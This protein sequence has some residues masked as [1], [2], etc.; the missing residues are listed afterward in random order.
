MEP[1]VD[2]A[3][4]P[5][6]EF[7]NNSC[8]AEPV[9]DQAQEVLISS[10]GENLHKQRGSNTAS[11]TLAETAHTLSD[12]TLGPAAATEVH[13]QPCSD[14]MADM[15]SQEQTSFSTL[16]SKSDIVADGGHSAIKKGVK[17]SGISDSEAAQ[18]LQ[19][20]FKSDTSRNLSPKSPVP[21]LLS[22]GALSRSLGSLPLN[23]DVAIS[24]QEVILPF[25][26]TQGEDTLK[27]DAQNKQDTSEKGNKPIPP[28][29][30]ALPAKPT[31]P[32][33]PSLPSTSTVQMRP[34]PP[35]PAKPPVP[36]S[37]RLSALS[38]RSSASDNA[39]D[40][41]FSTIS[42]D[43]QDTITLSSTFTFLT[44]TVTSSITSET[45]NITSPWTS[46]SS[47]PSELGSPTELPMDITSEV[48]NLIQIPS[49]PSSIITSPDSS[50]APSPGSSA[51]PSPASSLRASP[52]A[53][54]RPKRARKFRQYN[55][56]SSCDGDR[57]DISSI[58]GELNL[59]IVIY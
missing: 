9:V 54:P 14:S 53:P 16:A 4:P 2:P 31:L 13:G 44:S 52:R 48:Q 58:T 51:V 56:L 43:S 57:S 3:P 23:P 33:K 46:T 36:K 25:Q 32:A 45:S 50:V 8:I 37:L 49:A 18:C 15:A 1:L 41:V 59:T 6:P 42:S 35:L 38:D 26:C 17:Q 30:P 19:S 27:N 55:S 12:N 20:D 24:D 7:A 47:A 28:S 11:Q 29:K 22:Q 34:K 10:A 40:S 39:R 21:L 5:P